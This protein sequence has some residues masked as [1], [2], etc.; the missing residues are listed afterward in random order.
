MRLN[1]GCQSNLSHTFHILLP[2]CI[3]LDNET[4]ETKFYGDWDFHHSGRGEHH[5]VVEDEKELDDMM[6][7]FV[8]CNW[9]DT[10]WQQYSTHLHTNSTQNDTM[11]QNTQNEHT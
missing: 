11:K 1:W 10:R 5:S 2:N 6:I 4:V 9:V 8:K 3:T 7:Y